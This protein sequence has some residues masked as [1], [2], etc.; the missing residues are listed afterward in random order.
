MPD[1]REVWLADLNPK[2]GTEPGKTQTA[3]IVEA[4]AL[5]NAYH[6]LTLIIPL[7]TKL[8]NDTDPLRHRVAAVGQVRRDADLLIDQV[9]AIDNRRLVQGP[10]THLPSAFMQRVDDAINDV[11]DLEYSSI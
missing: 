7:S 5:L 11:L 9:R 2:H 10:V 3:L 1:R 8:V 4:Q 6:P